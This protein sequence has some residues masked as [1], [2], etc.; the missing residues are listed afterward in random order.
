MTYR[1]NH[2]RYLE[3]V[4]RR[5]FAEQPKEQ[6]KAEALPI[7]LIKPDYIQVMI[8][9]VKLDGSLKIL[10]PDLAA[11]VGF[12]AKDKSALNDC[13]R[14]MYAGGISYSLQGDE[15]TFSVRQL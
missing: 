3:Q 11:L 10:C 1:T 13:V 15:I 12:S 9:A 2:D 6:P 14:K 7:P 4:E 8:E 5:R